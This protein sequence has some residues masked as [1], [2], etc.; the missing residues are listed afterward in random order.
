MSD[1]A[2]S[3]LGDPL[4]PGSPAA[5]LNPVCVIVRAGPG[6]DLLHERLDASNGLGDELLQLALAERVL[7][8]APEAIPL[9]MAAHR[10][11]VATPATADSALALEVSSWARGSVIPG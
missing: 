1:I 7:E 5:S 11:I 9:L 8:P 2:D 3:R 10:P 6:S 4:G